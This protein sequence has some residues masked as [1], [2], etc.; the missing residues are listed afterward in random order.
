MFSVV[1]C[2]FRSW[3]PVK[4]V[5]CSTLADRQQGNSC[6]Q[7]CCVSVGQHTSC[8]LLTGEGDVNQHDRQAQQINKLSIDATRAVEMCLAPPEC[9][10]VKSSPHQF[11]YGGGGFAVTLTFDLW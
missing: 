11:I 6:R 1:V 8:Q 10:Y 2:V 4:T 5:D 9:M 7:Q 3:R